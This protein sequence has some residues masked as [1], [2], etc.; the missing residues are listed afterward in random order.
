MHTRVNASDRC[1]ARSKEY[2]MI[3]TAIYV[4]GLAVFTGSLMF[5]MKKLD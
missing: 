1:E 3:A 4:A 5:A 2:T